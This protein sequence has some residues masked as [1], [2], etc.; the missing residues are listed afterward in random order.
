MNEG[1]DSESL[2]KTAG[3][4]AVASGMKGIKEVT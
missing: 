3:I 2:L 1:P 4:G